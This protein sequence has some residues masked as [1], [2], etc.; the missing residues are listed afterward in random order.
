MLGEAVNPRNFNTLRRIE[1]EDE[2]VI[3]EQGEVLELTSSEMLLGHLRD[4]LAR[5]GREMVEDLPDGIHS[6]LARPG[7]RGLFF[8][9]TAA[10]RATEGKLHFWRYCDLH[11]NTIRDNRY[12]IAQLIAC[13]PD[14]PRVIGEADVFAIQERVMDDL[15]GT[16]QRQQAMEGVPNIVDGAQNLV[17][18]V[19]QNQLNK[20]GLSRREVRAALKALRRPLQRAYLRDLR[21]AYDAYQRDGDVSALLETVNQTVDA[22]A[23]A[24]E[25]ATPTAPAL[26]R[27]DLHLVCWEY[28]W[29]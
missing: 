7:Y 11:D 23:A 1:E 24:A 9:F 29:S 13:A 2:S 8:C 14:T 4:V 19:L 5:E 20:P 15:L 28:V 27:E 21:G 25:S 26:Q 18:S 6:G 3:E 22:S 16:V 17:T 10:D 12:E